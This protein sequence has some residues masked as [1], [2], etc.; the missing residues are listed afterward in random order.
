MNT[1]LITG[2]SG[3]I[4]T[5]LLE[6][7]KDA[8]EIR[9]FSRSEK[10]QIPLKKL[11]PKVKF[12]VGDIRDLQAVKNAMRGADIVIHTAAFK[13]ADIAESQ[14]RETALINVVGSINVID[15]ALS[16]PSVKKVIGL[17]SDKAAYAR[18]VY[19]AT[20]HILEKL[21]R[22]ANSQSDKLFSCVRYGNVIGSN[23]S[24]FK[25]WESQKAAGTPLTITD[26]RMRRL[27]FTLDDA[28]DLIFDAMKHMQGGEVFAMKMKSYSLYDLA[29]TISPNI[30]ETGI[31]PGEKLNEVLIADYEGEEF[32]SEHSGNNEIVV[33]R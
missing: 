1:Y 6:R 21:F 33:I 27:F 2:G 19:G 17:S 7:I 28:V 12:I 26:K 22:E 16:E 29:K 15:A 31:R 10:N 11:Y 13:Y 9:V 8:D 25:I 14:A 32:T 23:G 24:V 18:N 3:S 20:K 30:I 5:H 4:G